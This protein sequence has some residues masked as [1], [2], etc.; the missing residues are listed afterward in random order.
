M[1]TKPLSHLRHTIRR[2]WTYLLIGLCAWLALPAYADVSSGLQWLDGRETATG[3]HLSTDIA[4]LADTN[5]EAWLT[6]S[7]LSES[8]RFPLLGAAVLTGR[9]QSSASLAKLILIRIGQ[10]QSSAEL[11]AQILALQNGDGGFGARAGY[12]SEALTTAFVLLGNP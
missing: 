2:G 7:T 5:A 4:E 12:Q 9:D 11:I 3:V 6:V 8:Q 10:G 1:T